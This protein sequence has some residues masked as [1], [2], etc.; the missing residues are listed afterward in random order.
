M[1]GNRLSKTGY[2]E[3][4]NW[5]RQGCELKYILLLLIVFQERRL[6]HNNKM[7]IELKWRSKKKKDWTIEGT[8]WRLTIIANS[9][10]GLTVYARYCCYTFHPQDNLWSMYYYHFHFTEVSGLCPR[11]QTTRMCMLVLK[12]VL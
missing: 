4:L 1:E 2:V 10:L 9:Y 8:P 3:N 6:E 7:L 12:F 11:S 5:D